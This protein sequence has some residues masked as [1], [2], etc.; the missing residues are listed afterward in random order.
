MNRMMLMAAI[1]LL[2]A[3]GGGGSHESGGSAPTLSD[4]QFTPQ[5]IR[6][7]EPGSTFSAVMRMAFSDVD[8][9]VATL[10]VSSEGQTHDLPIQG[11]TG[12]TSGTLE[13][14]VTF[15]ASAIHAYS[16][17]ATLIDAKGHA[18]A[19]AIAVF[20]VV[21]PQPVLQYLSPAGVVAGGPAFDLRVYGGTFTPSSVVQWN[22]MPRATTYLNENTLVARISAEDISRSS[23]VQISVLNAMLDG[24]SSL[25]VPLDVSTLNILTL[26]GEANDV[27]WDSNLNRLYVSYPASNPWHPNEVLAV[28]PQTGN[29]LA[30][31]SPGQ[32]PNR[33]S[34][35]PDGG[36]LYV[37]VD[38]VNAVKRFRL[39]DLAEELSIPLGFDASG[40]P[41]VAVDLQTSPI[42]G[43]TI[44][45]S[46]GY[47]DIS[48]RAGWGVF[49]YDDAAARERALPNWMSGGGICGSLQWGSDGS[50]LYASDTDTTGFE[51][52][53]MTVD[54]NGIGALSTYPNVFT[55]FQAR[56]HFDPGMNLVYSDSGDVVDPGSGTKVGT[57]GI[58][59]PMAPVS[60][61]GSAYILERDPSYPGGKFWIRKM[62][63]ATRDLVASAPVTGN[64]DPYNPSVFP[65]HVVP[66]GGWG[67]AATGKGMPLMVISGSFFPLQSHL[68]SVVETAP[69]GRSAPAM[70]E[71]VHLP[72][73]FGPARGTERAPD[74]RPR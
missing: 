36:R 38:G 52:Y 34:L 35:A 12:M 1:A 33:L 37:G 55:T 60:T 7:M 26:P 62:N 28:D 71:G 42:D 22:G 40:R 19:E 53:R 32:D 21:A 5:D 25:S 45:I 20:S 13:A 54:G 56:L 2:A 43:R 70:V 74:P 39:P 47:T 15:N 14:T 69:S 16:F 4:F 23:T 65:A 17:H 24:G 44:A 9:D 51:F 10:R 72:I 30:K 49:I 61:T 18:S 3:C 31:I 41:F 8:G 11:V 67:L 57:F 46:K 66:L 68:T 50:V 58:R 6:V 59:G 48:P 27:V 73:H 29:I 64:L 63:L